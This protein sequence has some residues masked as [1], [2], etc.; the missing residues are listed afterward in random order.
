[1]VSEGRG[2]K[3]FKDSDHLD[4]E[5]IEIFD[6]EGD[7]IDLEEASVDSFEETL[8]PIKARDSTKCWR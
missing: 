2:K 1:M 6:G 5:D 7:D 3:L 8:P 4:A